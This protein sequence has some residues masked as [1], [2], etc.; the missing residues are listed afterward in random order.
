MNEH[1]IESQIHTIP[2]KMTLQP[3]L[4][5]KK[6]QSVLNKYI[7]PLLKNK[8]IELQDVGESFHTLL[9]PLRLERI[10]ENR[11]FYLILKGSSHS[12]KPVTVL[13]NPSK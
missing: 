1:I 9:S 8:G 10:Q 6:E 13:I 2:Y 11:S 4:L 5:G 12:K 3:Q 7:M